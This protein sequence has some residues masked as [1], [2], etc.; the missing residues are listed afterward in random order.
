MSCCT[1]K[2]SCVDSSLLH[3]CPLQIKVHA[4][5][6]LSCSPCLPAAEEATSLQLNTA[7]K[8]GRLSEALRLYYQAAS[9]NPQ[10]HALFNNI[11]FAALKNG[12]P[13][14]VCDMSC[15]AL[16]CAAVCAMLSHTP[17]PACLT[18]PHMEMLCVFGARHACCRRVYCN[19]SSSSTQ[20]AG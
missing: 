5:C 14:Q 2:H 10:D 7:F 4:Y 16:C 17:G 19:R 20:Q 3:A 18:V 1:T 8:E 6:T 13:H 15:A 11:S 9:H 12:D